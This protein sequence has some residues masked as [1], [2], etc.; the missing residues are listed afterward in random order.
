MQDN[1]HEEVN[2]MVT[3]DNIEVKE[4]RAEKLGVSATPIAKRSGASQAALSGIVSGAFGCDSAAHFLEIYNM[5]VE[6]RATL[7][8]LGLWKGSA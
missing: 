3:F 5:V 6:L 1:Q 7:V 2:F 4:L 8:A